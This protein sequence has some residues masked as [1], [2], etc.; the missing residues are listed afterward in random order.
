MMVFSIL[1][2]IFFIIICIY[3]KNRLQ[4]SIFKD[5]KTIPSVPFASLYNT[6]VRHILSESQLIYHCAQ[7]A[8]ENIWVGSLESVKLQKSCRGRKLHASIWIRKAD[9]GPGRVFV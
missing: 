5:L 7:I 2:S 4:Q 1:L 8:A 6:T 3:L 9:R